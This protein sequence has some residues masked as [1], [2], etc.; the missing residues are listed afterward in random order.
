MNWMG[1]LLIFA[2]ALGYAT[3]SMLL[4]AICLALVRPRTLADA[5]F[6]SACAITVV[7]VMEIEGGG[8]EGFV[9]ASGI[10]AFV[11][12]ITLYMV[13]LAIIG[14]QQDKQKSEKAQFGETIGKVTPINKI[15]TFMISFGI[16][17]ASFYG[18]AVILD[19]IFRSRTINWLGGITVGLLIW[20][21]AFKMLSRFKNATD[22]VY[23]AVSS[24]KNVRDVVASRM[25]E[26]DASY[27]AQAEKEITNGNQDE[28][29]WA[30]ALVKAEGNSEKRKIEYMKLRVKHLK[31]K[32]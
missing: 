11:I 10:L 13:V 29:L 9:I 12:S 27:Y 25:A 3:T 14:N 17:F 24:F 22:I 26:N 31:Q 19:D 21:I 20:R 8:A 7:S 23:S 6:T 5:S 18:T 16:G 15:L 2:S 28:D 30:L 1:L 32:T 4:A